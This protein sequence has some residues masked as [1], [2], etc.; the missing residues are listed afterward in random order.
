MR[1]RDAVGGV[2]PALVRQP[3]LRP[4]PVLDETVAVEVA[5]QVEPLEG[6]VDRAAQLPEQLERARPRAL[7]AEHAEEERRRVDAPVMAGKG[8]FAE[9]GGLSHAQLV[10]DLPG[11][12]VARVVGAPAEPGRE[13]AQR[14]RG[15]VGREAQRLEAGDQAVAAEQR[16]EPGDPSRVVRAAVEVRAEQLEVEQRALEDAVE[17]AVV[18]RHADRRRPGAGGRDRRRPAARPVLLGDRVDKLDHDRP[19]R[20]EL[21][22]E[23][24]LA[25][26]PGRGLRRDAHSRAPPNAVPPEHRERLAVPNG[27][28]TVAAG[29]ESAQHE[30]RLEVR[31]EAERERQTER[32]AVMTADR[33]PLAQ[34]TAGVRPANEPY[35]Q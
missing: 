10:Q 1:V 14:P 23:A 11:L 3:R 34:H 31:G 32:R 9:R 24:E 28:R 18:R 13:Q 20:L 22:L 4:A 6:G 21:E 25:P 27:L 19:A 30:H 15:D 2:L 5:V 16:G 33:D 12:L 35:E 26:G 29:H 8:R 7:A 17:Q